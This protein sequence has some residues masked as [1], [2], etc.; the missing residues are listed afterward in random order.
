MNLI[1]A[2]QA[3][4]DGKTV[5]CTSDHRFYKMWDD[6]Q[7]V[8]ASSQEYNWCV[9]VGPSLSGFYL[10]R[11]NFVLVKTKTCFSALKVGQAFYYKDK[12][13]TKVAVIGCYQTPCEEY[14]GKCGVEFTKFCP[15]E[16]VEID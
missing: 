4:K 7:I 12:T 5:K 16:Q 6:G 13:Y 3:M 9:G 11:S 8:S 14:Y 1:E 2:L 10:N 15:S